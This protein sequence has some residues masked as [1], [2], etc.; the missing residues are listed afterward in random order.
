MFCTQCGNR[1]EVEYARFCPSCGNPVIAYNAPVQRPQP[2]AAPAPAPKKIGAGKAIAATIVLVLVVGFFVAVAESTDDDD[3]SKRIDIV[4]LTEDTY[5]ELSGDFLTEKDIFTVSLTD[6]GKIAFALN[7]DVSIK[8]DY[9]EWKF[10]DR[11]HVSSTSDTV[12]REYTG[13]IVSKAEPVLYY[14]SQSVGEYDVSV[15]CYVES[16]GKRTYSESYSGTV[17]YVGSVTKEYKWLYKGVSY[18]AQTTFGYD[19]Y[20]EYRDKDPYGRTVTNYSKVVSFVT[21]ED[22]SIK[23]L[24]ESL[25]DAYGIG[26]DTTGQ[27]FASFVLAFVQICFEYPP[28]TAYMDGDT[29]LYGVDDYFAYPLETIFYGLGDCEDT[30]ILAAALFKALGYEAGVFVIPG[31]A[32]AGVGLDSYS[33]GAYSKSYYE[34]LSQTVN[35]I[36]YYA[37]ETTTSTPLGVGLVSSDG[38]DGTPY[39]YYVGKQRFGI[40][41]V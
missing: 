12:Y 32:V 20:R 24:A 6:D 26:K 7:D 31:H 33:P 21:Y 16:G 13:D 29:F 34:V 22:P 3:S 35:G 25:R 23:A 2:F 37:C 11:D 18:S 4:T 17:S 40:Y 5:L 28:F 9:Y 14:L 10:F 27:D 39:S 38:S 1:L 41:V 8:Y 15:K 36:T 19:E 30:S